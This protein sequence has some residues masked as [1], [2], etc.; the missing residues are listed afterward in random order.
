MSSFLSR[1]SSILSFPTY[2]LPSLP[3]RRKGSSDSTACSASSSASSPTANTFSEPTGPPDLASDSLGPPVSYIR[4]A[5]CAAELCLTDQIVSRGF[6]GRFGRAYLVAP[7]E[8]SRSTSARKVTIPSLPNTHTL[9]AV[10]RQLVTGAHTVSDVICAG[11]GVGLG[12]KYVHAEE[13]SQRYKIGKFILETKRISIASRWERDAYDDDE[14]GVSDGD[15]GG[16][17]ADAGLEELMRPTL[18]N[19][20]DVEFDSQDEEECEDLFAGSWSAEAVAKRRK[21]R[22]F[23]KN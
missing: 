3:F 19:G 21:A 4:C 6:T 9:K 23:V 14:P 7:L 15:W 8:S 1:P 18:V 16:A 12:W 10:P 13:E 22:R 5:R 11:C 17:V 2:I 20:L